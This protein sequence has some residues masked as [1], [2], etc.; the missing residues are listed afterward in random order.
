MKISKVTKTILDNRVEY[1]NSEGEFHRT[2]GP[3]IERVDGTKEWWLNGKRHREDGAAVEYSSG[4][5]WWYL[6]GKL[7]R[8]DGPAAEYPNGANF[9]YLNDEYHRTDGPAIELASGTRE[10]YLDGKE[11]T[12]E[13]FN[14][15]TVN[16]TLRETSAHKTLDDAFEAAMQDEPEESG[17]TREHLLAMVNSQTAMI[18]ELSEKLNQYRDA[19][20]ERKAK[21]MFNAIYPDI[22][23]NVELAQDW[24]SLA[25]E[26]EFKG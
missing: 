4:T 20:R 8:T 6:N 21:R 13:E 23:F 12:E 3:A 16:L 24:L 11:L 26:I 1:R 25:D 15:R 19:E 5:K 18:R 7:H 17:I 9:W 14:T 2:D 10:W 22:K